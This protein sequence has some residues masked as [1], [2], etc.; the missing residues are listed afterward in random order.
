MDRIS[1]HNSQLTTHNSQLTTHNSQLPRFAVP[2]Q[3]GLR[4]EPQSSLMLA[5]RSKFKILLPLF[6]CRWPSALRFGCVPWRPWRLGGSSSSSS[7]PSSPSLRRMDRRPYSHPGN[8]H[9]AR[10]QGQ[11]ATGARRG[12]VRQ[13]PAGAKCDSHRLPLQEWRPGDQAGTMAGLPQDQVV[14]HSLQVVVKAGRQAVSG[15]AHF[16][17]DG[18]LPVPGLFRALPG[19]RCG[20]IHGLGFR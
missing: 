5:T 20:A 19:Y 4:R 16:A 18:I 14:C 15:I 13:G 9:A 7:V 12:K 1:L 6:L 11:S 17:D 2:C 8:S 10:P 3:L